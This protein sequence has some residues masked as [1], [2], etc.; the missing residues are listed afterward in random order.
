LDKKLNNSNL[1]NLS[2]VIPVYNALEE[3]IACIK[4]LIKSDAG[5]CKIVLMDDASDLT[6]KEKLNKIFETNSNIKVFS[7]FRNKGYTH[8]ISMGIN[9][10]ST[11]YVCILNSDT[12]LPNIWAKPMIEKLCNNS[13]IAGIGPLSNAA[14]YQSIPLL[15]DP[16]TNKFS[17]ND[18]LGFDPKDR[19]LISSL[20]GNIVKNFF[21]DV[22]NLN[23]FCT[24]FRRNAL[25]NVGGFDI[26]NF[27]EGYGEEN[28]LCIRL[29]ARGYRLNVSMSTFVHHQ[30]TKS[31]DNSRKINLQKKGMEKLHNKFGKNLMINMINYIWVN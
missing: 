19:F 23:G 22:P 21:V 14:S 17:V 29:K 7:H 6:V 2:I 25:D 3:T 16:I 31:F 9:Q 27:R 15:V 4:S 20:L 30:K 5:G 1:Q 28:D 12:L 24:I 11:E 26:Q 13:Q 18:N 10:T 8:N